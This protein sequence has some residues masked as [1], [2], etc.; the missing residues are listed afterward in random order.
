MRMSSG[1][2]AYATSVLS[3]LSTEA[4]SYTAPSSSAGVDIDMSVGEVKLKAFQDEIPSIIPPR[5]LTW[6]YSKPEG[7]TPLR[8]AY[9]EALRLNGHDVGHLGPNNVVI[10]SG[11][12]QALWL[13]F[14]MTA[15]TGTRV[16][17]PDPGWAPYRI[18]ATALGANYVFYDAGG[19]VCRQLRL[20]A[21]GVLLLNSPNNPTGLELSQEELDLIYRRAEDCGTTIIADEVYRVFGEHPASLVGRVTPVGSPVFVADSLSKAYA[22]AGIRV[23]FLVTGQD[24]AADAVQIRSALDSCPPSVTQAVALALLR[25]YPRM[26]ATRDFAGSTRA[27]LGALLVKDGHRVASEGAL[28]CWVQPN[29]DLHP[30]PETLICAG[31]TIKGVAGSLFGRPGYVRLCPTSDAETFINFLDGDC[32]AR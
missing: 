4:A 3:A 28:Y 13:A 5:D 18:L 10:T 1:Y 7:S 6:N 32:N 21:G 9:L 12:K 14:V 26:T 8:E 27:R 24:R 15:R 31:R 22:A 11:G 16:L 17:L 25:K 30:G 23:G 29:P 19:K 2:S 20:C